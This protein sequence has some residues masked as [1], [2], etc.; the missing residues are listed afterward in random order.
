[1]C[2]HLRFFH[3]LEAMIEGQ[4]QVQISFVQI[5][6]FFHINQHANGK[7]ENLHHVKISRYTVY[8]L[9]R[10]HPHPPSSH[11][12]P[13]PLPLRS[14]PCPF[15]SP[16]PPLPLPCLHLPSPPSP[17]FPTSYPLPTSQIKY[18]LPPTTFPPSP[19][20]RR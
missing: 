7:R 19:L 9:N 15:P 20:F 11:T 1:M 16:F 5:F 4:G 14:F 8:D 13:F 2:I 6:T 18:S 17:P 10:H 3:S 12:H